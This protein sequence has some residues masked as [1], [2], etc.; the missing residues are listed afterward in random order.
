MGHKPQ[1]RKNMTT[2]KK[3]QR[4]LEEADKKGYIKPDERFYLASSEWVISDQKGWDDEDQAK[5]CD[6]STSKYW[7]LPDPPV[8]AFGNFIGV[9]I[10]TAEELTEHLDT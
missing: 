3:A 9:G 5:D 1:R 6:F 10:D 8:D 2:L 7:I 4:L